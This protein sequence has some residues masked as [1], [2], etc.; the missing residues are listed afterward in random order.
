MQSNQVPS[1]FHQLLYFM[2]FLNKI[3]RRARIG[4]SFARWHLAIAITSIY[5][6]D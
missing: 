3:Q 5:N 6:K 1:I 4:K 2:T